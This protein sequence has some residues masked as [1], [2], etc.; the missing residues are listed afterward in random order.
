MKMKVIW[1]PE[2]RKPEEWVID[3]GNPDW[4]LSY[5]IEK[6]T[7]WSWSEFLE[8]IDATSV[9]AWRALLWALRRAEEPRLPIAA[10]KFV[11]DEVTVEVQCLGCGGWI[12]DDGHECATPVEVEEPAEDAD[13]EAPKKGGK[14]KAGED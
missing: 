5:P 4:T 2:A 13:A 1:T 7:G 10:V 6:E 14:T 9:I 12:F 8:R 3:R 11:F